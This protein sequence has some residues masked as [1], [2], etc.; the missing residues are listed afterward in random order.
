MSVNMKDSVLK[1]AWRRHKTSRAGRP[2]TGD[3]GEKDAEWIYRAVHDS[4]LQIISV[5]GK[6]VKGMSP[7]SHNFWYSHPWVSSDML[8]QFMFHMDP[9]ARGLTKNINGDGLYF[10]TFPEN[11]PDRIVEILDRA[12]QIQN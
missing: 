5:D 4:H 3:L 1:M 12:K 7:R 2:D 10:W 8:I 6:T 11:Y 9:L